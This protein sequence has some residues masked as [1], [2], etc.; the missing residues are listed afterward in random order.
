M[1]FRTLRQTA[2]QAITSTS[3]L[4]HLSYIDLKFS[5]NIDAIGG[6]FQLQVL[7]GVANVEIDGDRRRFVQH[8]VKT[9]LDAFLVLGLVGIRLVC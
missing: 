6:G 8:G 9:I 2:E 3:R 7:G 5:G 1:L 4:G